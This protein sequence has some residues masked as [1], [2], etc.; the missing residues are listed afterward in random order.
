MSRIIASAAIRGAHAMMER[1]E[2]DLEKA[3]AAYGK[4]AP[5]A[6]PSTAYYLP[7]M[8]LFLGQKVQKL[9]DLSES[10]KEGRKLLGRIPEKSNWL[11]YLGETLDSGVATLIAEEAIEALKYVNGGN[12]ANGLWLG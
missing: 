3:I 4:D 2:T 12:L 7:I 8:L 11:P 9:G 10:L 5:V 1:A 6:Y